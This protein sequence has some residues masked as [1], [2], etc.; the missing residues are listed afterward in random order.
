MR[1]AALLDDVTGMGSSHSARS[2]HLRLTEM[3]CDKYGEG[4]ISLKGVSKWFERGSIP[5]G[6]FTKIMRLRDDLDPR[7]YI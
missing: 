6:W 4:A 7:L 5:G 3:L 2:K 1:I